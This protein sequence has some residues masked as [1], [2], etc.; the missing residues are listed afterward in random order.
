MSFD[1][2][3][4]CVLLRAP[5]PCVGDRAPDAREFGR[6]FGFVLEGAFAPGAT[7]EGRFLG[8]VNEAAIC[9]FEATVGLTPGELKIP[10]GQITFCT[11]ERIEPETYF[12]Y[13]WIPYGIDASIDPATEP[14]TLVEFHLRAVPEGT[15]LTIVE[16]GFADVPARRRARAFR[17]NQRGWEAQSENLRVYVE[18]R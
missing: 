6:W 15:E 1:R 3:E 16:S 17:M 4:R 8:T 7:I 2:I 5:L 11:V 9:A 14:M 13:R 18:S 12:S 10:A